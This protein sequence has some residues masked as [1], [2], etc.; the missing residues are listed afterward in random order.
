MCQSHSSPSPQSHSYSRP[1]SHHDNTVISERDRSAIDHLEAL[2][3]ESSPDAT[4][5]VLS[6]IRKS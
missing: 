1:E 5:R 2:A 4:Y 3:T 6:Q